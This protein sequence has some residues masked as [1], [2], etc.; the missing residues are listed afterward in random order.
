VGGDDADEAP[1][2]RLGDDPGNNLGRNYDISSDG[3]RFLVV[4][5][6]NASNA[7]PPQLVVVQHFERC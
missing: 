6:V 4:K 5:P 1:E 7:S 3:Q 2:G